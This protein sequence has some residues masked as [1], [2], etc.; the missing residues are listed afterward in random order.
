M[1]VWKIIESHFHDRDVTAVQTDS[2]NTL[3]TEN[4]PELVNHQKFFVNVKNSCTLYCNFSNTL[5]QK[6]VMMCGEKMY[7]DNA[8]KQDFT[9]E[10]LVCCDIEMVLVDNKSCRIVSS[11]LYKQVNIFKIPVMVGSVLCH[12]QYTNLLKNEDEFNNGGYFILKGK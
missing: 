1:D 5:L 11:Q 9:Y 7:P 3:V 2:Y 6:P 8:R 12:L 10:T 4:I